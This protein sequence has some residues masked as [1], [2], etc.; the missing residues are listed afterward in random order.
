MKLLR[1]DA[2]RRSLALLGAAL[3]LY[4]LGWSGALRHPL[5]WLASLVGAF[6]SCVINHNHQHA[7]TFHTTRANRWMGAA[8][9]LAIG[10]P[11]SSITPMH[12]GNHHL[13]AGAAEDCVSPGIVRFRWNA[14]NLLLFPFV[15]IRT[16]RR[17]KSAGLREW[18]SGRP[19]ARRQLAFERALLYGATLA[20]LVAQPAETVAFLVLPWLFGQWAILAINLVQH[21]GCEPGNGPRGA[22]N[23]TGRALNWLLLNNGYHTVH[24]QRPVLHWSRL[25]EEH[26]R[27]RGSLP[28]E[29]DE[30]PFLATLF[31]LYVWPGK[32]PSMESPR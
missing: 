29:L 21:D 4:A 25:P 8:L 24:H 11:A 2:D 28:P 23:F 16:Y 3:A 30:Q 17:V 10:Q 13:H 22:R 18:T 9:S 15:A 7:P 27:L 31:R 20:L 6:V 32:R 26:A 19:R 1:H 5:V 12:S 14:L